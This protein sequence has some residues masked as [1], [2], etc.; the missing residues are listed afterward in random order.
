MP[1][2]PPSARAE[3]P[4]A[5]ILAIVEAYE[6]RGMDPSN[7]LQAAQITP[8]LLTRSTARVT[9][10]QME[11]MSAAAMR[12]LDDEALGWFSR[13][14]PWGSYGMLVRASLSAPN[15]SVALQRWGRHHGLLTEDIRVALHTQD[16]LAHLTL[17]EHRA[18]GAWREFC[19]VSVLRNALGV[20]CWLTDS[21]I[22][23]AGTTLRFAPP[24]HASSY[25]V[26]FD[27]PTTFNAEHHGLQFDAGYLKLPIRRDEA[28]LQRMLQRALLLTVRPYRRDRLLVE[29]V[30]QTLAEQPEHS[31]NAEDLAAWLNLS[32]RTLH[33]Q[34]R[35]EGATLQAL[36]DSV[37]RDK[38]T[39][40]LLRSERPIKQIAAEVG[41]QNDKSF[42][43]AFKLW[44][45]QTPEAFRT[46]DRR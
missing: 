20:A 21:R 23:L 17:T 27:G 39:H 13:R 7:A 38:A 25:R 22:P 3:T 8:S 35:E 12:E 11:W 26:L 31:R 30:R 10:L 19:V 14:L 34:L 32:T 16:G 46:A 29:K 43:R 33:R 40:L 2:P 18:L 41:F 36:K 28:A 24:A 6:R 45:G 37:R 44:T 42:M 9:A 4:I 5:F 15:L 1:T